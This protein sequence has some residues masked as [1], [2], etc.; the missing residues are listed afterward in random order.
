MSQLVKKVHALES[1]SKNLYGVV[2]KKE[3][4]IKDLELTNILSKN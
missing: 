3:K 1:E 2:I 4:K